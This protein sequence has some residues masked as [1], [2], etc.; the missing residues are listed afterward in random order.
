MPTIRFW[1]RT[2]PPGKFIQSAIFGGL[3]FLLSACQPVP[4]PS[5]VPTSYSAVLTATGMPLAA[6]LAESPVQQIPLSGPIDHPETELSGLAWD[7]DMLLMLPQY[8][9]RFTAGLPASDGALFALSKEDILAFLDGKIT[10]PLSP[11][12]VAVFAPGLRQKITGYEGFEATVVAG[13][14]IFFTIETKQT[15]GMVGILLAGEFNHDHTEIHIDTDKLIDISAQASLANF[16]DEALT[17]V[18]NQLVTFYE[19]NGTMYNPS[20]VAHIYDLLLDPGGVII[21]PNLE[22]RITDA[23]PADDQGRFW[24]MNYFFPGDTKIAPVIDPIIQKYGVPPAQSQAK[25][26]ERLVQFQFSENQIVLVDQPPIYLQL[27]PDGTSRN[28]EGLAQLDERGFLLVTDRYPETLFSFV[29][30]P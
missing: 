9:E 8:P 23:T 7:Q 16:S 14:R 1:K 28:W 4:V 12:L 26:I 19:A 24:V 10:G 30:L 6:T 29:K 2:W 17:L 20:P 3:F 5:A 27:M 18:K 22:Y 25:T 15:G 11:H 13:E 21:S